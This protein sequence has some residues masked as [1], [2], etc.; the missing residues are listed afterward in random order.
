LTQAPSLAAVYGGP[1]AGKQGH[2]RIPVIR[3]PDV[4][5]CVCRQ[6]LWEVDAAGAES[7]RAGEPLPG[8][9]ELHYVPVAAVDAAT[10][11]LVCNPDVVRAV[12]RQPIVLH[13]PGGGRGHLLHFAAGAKWRQLREHA[14]V[15]HNPGVT[16]GIEGHRGGQVHAAAAPCDRQSP[17]RHR[18]CGH[19]HKGRG[20][21]QQ[22][23]Q[24]DDMV[25]WIAQD[26]IDRI[27]GV[28]GSA[29][30][31]G[32][33]RRQQGGEGSA[34]AGCGATVQDVRQGVDLGGR[35]AESG[36][37]EAPGEVPVA[38]FASWLAAPNALASPAALELLAPTLPP[39]E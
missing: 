3:H 2:Q 6:P 26:V 30:A 36:G 24:H 38:I 5:G 16:A 25:G 28:A 19:R 18:A 13:Q 33:C 12:H 29:A 21:G 11:M 10:A 37:R 9:A 34:S 32:C 1:A 8:G 39:L 22:S 31:G 35:N 4:A 27:Q 23:V 7:I 15:A 20:G 14:V 17:L